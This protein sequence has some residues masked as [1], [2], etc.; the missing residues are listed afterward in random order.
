MSYLESFDSEILSRFGE[1]S[2]TSSIISFNNLIPSST[3]CVHISADR[4][5]NCEIYFVSATWSPVQS[6][7]LK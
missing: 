7:Y 5:V 1:A 4:G 3:A 2:S 6:P